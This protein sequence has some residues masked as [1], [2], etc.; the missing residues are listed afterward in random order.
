MFL[1]NYVSFFSHHIINYYYFKNVGD[2]MTSAKILDARR[3]QWI[4]SVQTDIMKTWQRF[5]F[6]KP[7]ESLFFQEKWKGVKNGNKT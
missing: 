6:M 2:S 5:G 1:F 3:F 4:P 7:S